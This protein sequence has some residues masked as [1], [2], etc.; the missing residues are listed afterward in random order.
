[1]ADREEEPKTVRCVRTTKRQVQHLSRGA[2]RF[3]FFSRLTFH[4]ICRLPMLSC[5]S[6]QGASLRYP[7]QVGQVG[8]CGR[9]HSSPSRVGEGSWSVFSSSPDHL[10]CSWLSRHLYSPSRAWFSIWV[11]SEQNRPV[12]G[13]VVTDFFLLLEKSIIPLFPPLWACGRRCAVLFA[14]ELRR[15]WQ[16]TQRNQRERTTL[17]KWQMSVFV[18][19]RGKRERR[20][21]TANMTSI[22]CPLSRCQH[23]SDQTQVTRL[24]EEPALSLDRE[25]CCNSRARSTGNR[26]GSTVA[27]RLSGRRSFVHAGASLSRREQLMVRLSSSTGVMSFQLCDRDCYPQC[28]PFSEQCCIALF[29]VLAV[30]HAFQSNSVARRQTAYGFR[31]LDPMKIVVACREEF[32]PARPFKV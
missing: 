9:Q 19:F 28:K 3:F 24:K 8:Y 26:R 21:Q 12:G 18:W 7:V 14:T 10:L 27:G 17:K 30:L 11:V 23:E 5:P 32:G 29:L 15:V 31:A 22:C 13:D 25:S 1:M 16:S 4:E 2:G 20:V 6:G